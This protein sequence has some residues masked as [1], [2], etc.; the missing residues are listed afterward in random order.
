MLLRFLSLAIGSLVVHQAVLAQVDRGAPLPRKPSLGAALAPP[1]SGSNEVVLARIIEGSTASSAGLRANDVILEV[2]GQKLNAR[3]ELAPAVLKVPLGNEIRFKVKRGTE[4]IELK[5]TQLEK[6]RQK[7]TDLN[8]KYDQVKAGDQRIRG[9]I[10]TPKTAGPHPTVFLIGG[11]GAY[12]LDG[13]FEAIPYGN[14]L[15]PLSKKFAIVRI[16]KPG[17]GDSEGPAAYTDLLF[18]EELAAYVAALKL[19][20]TLPEIDK[21]RIAI[22][23][24]S[25]GGT[26]GPLAAA[27]EPVRGLAVSG[28]LIK[29]LNEYMLENSRRQALLAGESPVEVE[30]SMK[31]LHG[32]CHYLFSE[33]L[34]PQEILSKHPEQKAGL[35]ELSPDNKTFS[36]VGIQ[37]FQQLAKQDVV[38]AL[39]K[40]DAKVLSLWGENEF[41]STKWDHEY[42]A[43]IVNRKN[44]GFGVFQVVPESDHG[45]NMTS[46]TKDSFA[47][48]GRPGA[49]FNPN[50]IEILAKWLDEVLK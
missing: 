31:R 28:T 9:I 25:M 35:A 44:P 2:N 27:Q 14:I 48:W 32:I 37:F 45:F 15:G 23:G 18:E 46:S 29:T 19:T 11:I 17:Q 33:Q 22:F 5:G 38:G 36:G 10:T 1:S 20:K 21:T 7:G 39:A 42:I 6:P 47:K 24:H 41:I 40:L 34:S 49:T 50:I 13:E 4:T 16:D 8:V 12:S 26:F 30:A 3:T 43:E